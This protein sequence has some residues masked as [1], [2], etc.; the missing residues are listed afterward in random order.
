MKI[1]VLTSSRADY[2]IY[3]PLLHELKDDT[4]FET[5]VIA[6]GT[7]LL[8]RFGHTVDTIYKDGFNVR[9]VPLHLEIG[10]SPQD[11]SLGMSETL[12]EFSAYYATHK[13]HLL[14]ALG[15]RYEMFAAVAATAPFNIPV[16]HIHGGETTLGAI[17][18]AFRHSIT[19]FSKYHFTTTE[20]YRK[21]VWQIT[22][23]RDYVYNV[24]ALSID[25]LQQLKLLEI[26][27]FREKYNIDLSRP[28]VLFTFHPETVAYEMNKSHIAEIIKAFRNLGNYQ[29]LVTMPNADTMGLMIREELEKSAIELPNITIVESF[30]SLG[31][32]SAMKHCSFMLGNSS[33]GFVEAAYFS[34]PVI[35]LGNRQKGRILT[36]NILTVPITKEDIINAVRAVEKTGAKVVEPVYGNGDTASAIIQ[37]I[38]QQLTLNHSRVEYI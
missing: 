38:K 6:F 32:L 20:E 11:I 33:S 1:G 36:P 35:N 9:E 12:R 21:R 13:Y 8:A 2:G 34:K 3:L 10:D 26:S 19:C 37:I 25:N 18:N 28:T 23:Y 17:D 31:Y 14:F 22:G 7:H 27:E 5:D 29:I 15:D 4:F 16:A 30:G 24:G